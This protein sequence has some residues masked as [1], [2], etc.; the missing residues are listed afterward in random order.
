MSFGHDRG[1]FPFPAPVYLGDR[2]D[3]NIAQGFFEGMIDEVRFYDRPL[4]AE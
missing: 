2:N 4:T 1:F 3:N